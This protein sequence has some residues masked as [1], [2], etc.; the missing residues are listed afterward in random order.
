MGAPRLMAPQTAWSLTAFWGAAVAREQPHWV[1]LPQ[2]LWVAE[3]TLGCESRP[4]SL[5]TLHGKP[6]IGRV[7]RMWD[8][9]QS[10]GESWLDIGIGELETLITNRSTWEALYL[11]F[12]SL[13]YIF[14]GQS[15]HLRSWSL[16]LP[17]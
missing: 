16:A 1:S 15:E 9:P 13:P 8:P 14:N 7:S 12:R 17:S 3:G 11:L 6:C 2:L 10:R 4:H 5:P